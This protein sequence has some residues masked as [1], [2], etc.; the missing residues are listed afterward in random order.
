M[1]IVPDS[2]VFMSLSFL[3]A[4]AMEEKKLKQTFIFKLFSLSVK[5]RNV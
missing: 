2:V 4:L 1:F 5:L 3:Q